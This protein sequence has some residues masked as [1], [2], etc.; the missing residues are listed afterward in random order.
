MVYF[1]IIMVVYFSITIYTRTFIYKPVCGCMIIL[2]DIATFE[3]DT[4]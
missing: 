4:P 3:V 2:V 1:S